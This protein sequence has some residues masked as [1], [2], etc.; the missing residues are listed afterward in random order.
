MVTKNVF[1]SKLSETIFNSKYAHMGCETWDTL[2]NT[3]VEEVIQDGLSKSEKSDMKKIMREMK[4]IPGGRYLYYAGRGVKFYNNCYLL[5]AEEDSREDWA[6]LSWKSESC[7]TTGGGIGTDYSVYRPRGAILSRTGGQASGAVSKM[8]MVN[9]IGREVMQGAGRRSAIYASLNW[10]HGDIPDFLG[11][12]DWHNIRVPGT[13]ASLAD[14]KRAGF[15]FPAPLDMT[16]I[17]VNYDTEWLMNYYKTGDPGDVFLKNVE[18]ALRTG[19]PGFSFNF[20]E[21]ETE[22]LRNAC[23][24][25]TSSDDS[26][27]CNL[28]SVNLSRIDSIG[29]LAA[30]VELGTKFL[31]FGTLRAQLPYE[32]IARVREKNRRLGLGLMGVHEW[33]LKR[34]YRYEVVP[35]LHSWL[36]VYKGVS[37]H[38][39]RSEAARLD[40]S[41]PVANRAIAPTGTIGMLA[42]TTTGI[43]PVYAVAYKRRYLVEGKRWKYQYAVDSVA[44]DLVNLGVDPENIESAIDLAEDFERRIQ[45]QADV[46]DYVDMAISSTINLPAWGSKHNN[47]DCVRPFAD[48]LASR[49]SRLRGFTCY[50]DGS[51]G[52]QPLSSVPYLEAV[53][54]LGEEFEENT[55]YND[56]CEISGHGGSCGI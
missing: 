30:V 50:P 20:F 6:N 9:E 35:E 49:A 2:V 11:A 19:E 1:R 40:V 33:L 25:V 32:K 29:E 41:T 45:F 42:G 37:D 7:L 13:D 15:D 14:V 27:V 48:A 38:V 4:F 21:K 22:T 16:N 55:Q 47:P 51:R 53:E 54:K 10:K 39:S 36:S 8:R 56:I 17:S 23:T 44:Q 26:D 12:K 46:Q 52:G 5:R 3:L 28:G 43:E 34:A 31:L 24:E 18:Q